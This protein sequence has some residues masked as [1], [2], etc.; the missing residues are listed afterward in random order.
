MPMRRPHLMALLALAVLLGPGPAGVAAAPTLKAAT[1]MPLW[2]PQAQFAGYYV[3]QAK[4]LYARQGIDLRLLPAGPGQSPAT[5]LQ[6][7]RAD[8]AILWLTTAITHRANGLPLRHLAQISQKSS[9]LLI[10]RKASGIRSIADMAGRRVGL[11]PGDVAIPARTLF[12]SRGIQVREVPQG[13]TLNLFLRGGLDVASAT[14]YNEYHTLHSSG[15]DPEELNVVFLSEQGL[16]F[17][18]DGLYALE[19]TVQRDPA[20]VRGF[21]EASLEG[22]RLAFA[23]PEE[24]LD[25]VLRITREARQPANRMHQRWMLDRMRDLMQPATPGGR[26]GELR[27]ADYAAVAQAMVRLQFIPRAPDPAPSFLWRPDAPTP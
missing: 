10:S 7:G 24:T 18:E 27:E 13:Q 21:I 16:N 26:P 2:T 6:E 3:A 4:G 1:L 12:A 15:L 11:W 23:H 5:A 8:F 20:L 22:W 17:P 25:L 19:S 14:W 9:L